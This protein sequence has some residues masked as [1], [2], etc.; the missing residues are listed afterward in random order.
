MTSTHANGIVRLGSAF[1]NQIGF[2]PDRFS[3]DSYLW[4]DGDT[5][6]VSFVVSTQPGKGNFRRMVARCHAL[7][8]AVKIPTPL[9]RMLRIVIVNGYRRAMEHDEVSGEQVEVW[10]LAPPSKGAQP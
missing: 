8:L 6:M 5:V 3:A 2:T 7:G 10:G 4:L 1:A 9:G